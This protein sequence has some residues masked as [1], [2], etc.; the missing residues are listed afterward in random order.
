MK[1]RLAIRGDLLDFTAEP[2]WGDRVRRVRFRPT[3]GCSSKTAASPRC[4]RRRRAPT[5]RAT[6][7][8]GRLVLPG[9]VDTTCTARSST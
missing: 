5:G 6:D 3:T 4:R 2:G 7:H 9:F 8:A 1:T